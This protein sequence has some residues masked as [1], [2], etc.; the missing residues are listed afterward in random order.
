MTE[1]AQGLPRKKGVIRTVTG[2]IHGMKDPRR[3]EAAYLPVL[4]EAD[5]VADHGRPNT[6]TDR[7]VKIA[8]H[9]TMRDETTN[10][11]RLVME[12]SEFQIETMTGV[13]IIS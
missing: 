8:A 12:T 7:G 11:A 13:D 9:V 10:D 2:T 4:M 1:I 3:L 6:V 5:V